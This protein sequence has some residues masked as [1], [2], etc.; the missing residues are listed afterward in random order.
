MAHFEIKNLSFSYPASKNGPALKEIN[1]SIDRGEYIAVCGKSGSGKTT[2][3]K[4]LK[5]VL[6]PHGNVEGEIYF[7]GKPLEE[8]DLRQ[9]SAKIGYVMQNPDNQIVTDKV[10][11]ELAFGLES[12]GIDQ[13][14]IR[15]R[16]AEMA[17]YF[18]IQGWFHKNVTELSGGQKQRI[19]IARVFLKN[20]PILIL[21]EATSALDNESE[22]IVQDSLEKLAKGRTVF[23]IAHRLTTI[24]NANMILV[25]TENGIEEQGTH[26][27]LIDKKGLYYNLYS[28]YTSL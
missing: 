5:S 15:L 3:L 26:Q 8:S 6:S 23:T 7:E 22:K 19:S 24:R 2:L 18:G 10:W 11:H 20:P 28:M 12:L 1:L 17:S 21:D 4:H 25:L 27:E 13:K 14:T 9:Q 16:V